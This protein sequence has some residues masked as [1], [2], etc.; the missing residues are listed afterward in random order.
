[1]M[2]TEIQ[3]T[4]TR[5]RR[6]IILITADESIIDQIQSNNNP[7]LFESRI[8]DAIDD[9]PEIKHQHIVGEICSISSTIR[10]YYSLSN[11]H[12]LRRRKRQAC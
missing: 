2:S 9:E 6:R 4:E 5:K 12:N 7:S 10:I 11:I 3:P 8:L 1:M